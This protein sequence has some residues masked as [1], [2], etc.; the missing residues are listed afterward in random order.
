MAEAI[1]PE[2]GAEYKVSA[3]NSGVEISFAARDDE[4]F[5]LRSGSLRRYETIFR[6]M[7]ALVEQHL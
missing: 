6:K 5:K 1:S 3:I 2:L 4:D 7:V